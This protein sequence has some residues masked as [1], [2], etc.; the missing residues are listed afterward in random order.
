MCVRAK[1]KILQRKLKF[2]KYLSSL[3]KTQVD[4]NREEGD[5]NTIM[6]EHVRLQLF[7]SKHRTFENAS[8]SG[9]INKIRHQV[10]R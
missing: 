8:K 3:N 7:S 1:R 4:A 2:S 5:D 9:I 6:T 10:R